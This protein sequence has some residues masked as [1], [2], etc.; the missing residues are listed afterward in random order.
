MPDIAITCDGEEVNITRLDKA[1]GFNTL[2][3]LV[4]HASGEELS[5]TP[6]LYENGERLTIKCFTLEDAQRLTKRI[7][8]E[9]PN[10]IIGSAVE[11]T[12]IKKEDANPPDDDEGPKEELPKD[13]IQS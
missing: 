12:E 13:E 5:Y 8:S 11:K 2:T 4:E 3:D 7:Q 10:H 9:V 1:F 6:E